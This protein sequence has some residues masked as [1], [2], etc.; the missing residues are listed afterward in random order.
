MLMLLPLGSDEREARLPPAT[1]ALIAANLLVFLFTSSFD[2]VT[3]DARDTEVEEGADW[4]LRQAAQRVPALAA[5]LSMPAIAFLER[6][7]K[8]REDLAGTEARER[9]ESCLEDARQLRAA[10]PFYR[11]GFV[12]ARITL[13]SL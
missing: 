2:R 1:V 10:D 5:R 6:D 3:A 7:T 9:L 11:W 12:P 13:V 8:W 4:T